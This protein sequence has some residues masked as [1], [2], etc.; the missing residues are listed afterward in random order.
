MEKKQFSTKKV[1]AVRSQSACEYDEGSK[2][3][4]QRA[5]SKEC[6]AVLSAVV[7]LFLPLVA[8]GDCTAT[9]TASTSTLSCAGYLPGEDELLFMFGILMFFLSFNFW[10]RVFSITKGSY[11]L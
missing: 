11:D 8:F 10:E 5:W 4:K 6:A 1:R 7:I 3:E 9:T 2:A